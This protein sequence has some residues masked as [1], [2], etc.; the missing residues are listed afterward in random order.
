MEQAPGDQIHFDGEEA[1]TGH[2]AP[3]ADLFAAGFLIAL[4]ILVMIA[5]VQL[6]VPGGL[7]TAPGLLPFMTGASLAVMALM[8]GHSAWKRRKA[9]VVMHSDDARDHVEDKRVLLLAAVVAIYI[10]ALQFLAFQ[11]FWSIAGVSLVLSAFEPVTIVALSAII[12][13]SWRGALWVTVAI[14]AFWTI[15]L[16]LAFQKIFLIPLPGGF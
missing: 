8:L 3:G 12:H 10:L 7:R 6:P 16:S 9:G 11:V 4:S 2:S 15:F 1:G 13:V 5:S 14:S